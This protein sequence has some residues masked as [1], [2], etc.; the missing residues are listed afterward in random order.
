MWNR[1]LLR[2]LL[3]LQ[4]TS[5]R[6]LEGVNPLPLLGQVALV[7][8]GGRGIGRAVST[9]LAERGA[10]VALLY[11]SN[12]AAANA[13]LRSLPGEGHRCFQCEVTDAAAVER[14]VLNTSEGM[15]GLDILINNAG[16]YEDCDI[17]DPDLSYE[18]WQRVWDRTIQTNLIGP[19][20]LSFV[21]GRSMMSRAVPGRIINISS[22]GAYR[23]EPTTPAYGASKAGLNQLTQSLAKAL[24]GHGISVAGVAPG[25]VETE[26]AKSALEGPMGAAIRADSSFGRVA[27][28]E[29]VA[30]AVMFLVSE[31]ARFSTGTIVD[32]N[33][34]SYLR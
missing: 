23:G 10:R 20:N 3:S 18:D 32:V 34:A 5:S 25:F 19:A 26:M 22:R 1:A 12:E 16:I 15:G 6:S 8:G 4:A 29:E 13:T 14:V 17:Q 27:K 28:P 33:G 9:G 21:V 24:G 7:T 11:R 31:Q 30:E 2:R